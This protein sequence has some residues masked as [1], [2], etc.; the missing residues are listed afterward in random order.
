MS[1]Q[2]IREFLVER[3]EVALLKLSIHTKENEMANCSQIILGR[4]QI[5]AKQMEIFEREANRLKESLRNDDKA[6]IEAIIK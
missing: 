4:K 2:G 6:T 5:L 1:R 3:R